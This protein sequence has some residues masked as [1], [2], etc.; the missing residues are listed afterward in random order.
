LRDPLGVVPGLEVRCRID[1]II[2]GSVRHA[3][4]VAVRTHPNV[5]SLKAAR[6]VGVQLRRSVAAAHGTP[7][8]LGLAS[9]G[10]VLSGRGVV[11]GIVDDSCDIAHRNFRAADGSSRIAF[12]WDQAAGNPDPR[13]PAR[14]GYGREFSRATVTAALARPDPYTAL[15]YNPKHDAHGTHVLD[16]AAGSGDGTGVPGV[17]PGAEIIFVQLGVRDYDETGSL[18]NS[19]RLLDAVAYIF[20]KAAEMQLPAVVNLSVA[21][22]GGPHD[23]TTLVERG[24]ERL[25]AT[26]GR[27]IVI[28]AGNMGAAGTHASG[29]VAPGAP[30]TIGLRV[31]SADTT[32]NEVEVWY[33]GESSLRVTLNGPS[34]LTLGPVACGETRELLHKGKI[35]ARVVSVRS[36]PTNGAH[37]IHIFLRRR[38]PHGLWQVRFEASSPVSFH[39]WIERDDFGPFQQ[40]VFAEVDQDD[41]STLGTLGASVSAVVVAALDPDAATLLVPQFS[42]R[43]PT[44]TGGQKPDIAGPWRQHRGRCGPSRHRDAHALWDEYGR[45]PC[46]RC[47]C[48]TL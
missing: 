28:A 15:G 3:D 14:F 9:N 31:H 17:A 20:Q 40:S 24:F 4:V 42:A 1:D 35:A 32:D 16:V 44:R 18:G 33:T 45:T 29:V 36:D 46:E 43:G 25:L 13:S 41:T 47:H 7:T 11:V 48:T 19:S 8:A 12:L 2:T 5:R 39:A 21:M 38:A 6:P 37:Q 26:P 10:H 23:G 34:S 30:R 22:N 27:A